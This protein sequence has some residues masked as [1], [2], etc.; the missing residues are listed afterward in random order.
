MIDPYNRKFIESAED[1]KKAV[2]TKDIS[3]IIPALEYLK[4]LCF[5]DCQRLEKPSVKELFWMHFICGIYVAHVL[6]RYET[7]AEVPIAEIIAIQKELF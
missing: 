2:A 7:S 4:G 3:E 6:M 1:V 5:G